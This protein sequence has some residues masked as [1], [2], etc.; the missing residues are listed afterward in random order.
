MLCGGVRLLTQAKSL[1]QW[2]LVSCW[3]LKVEET[4][5]V[6][7]YKKERRSSAANE[8]SLPASSSSKDCLPSSIDIVC[9]I[10]ERQRRPSRGAKLHQAKAPWTQA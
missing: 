7:V 8:W 9:S 4:E 3:R 10:V 6:A 2:C 5:T 1:A